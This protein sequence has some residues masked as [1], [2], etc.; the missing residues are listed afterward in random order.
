MLRGV[1][2]VLQL[3]YDRVLQGPLK[4]MLDLGNWDE[5]NPDRDPVAG[6]EHFCAV[7]RIWTTAQHQGVDDT[8]A[9]I[10]D[11]AVDLLR[12]MLGL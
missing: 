11:Q 1:G 12:Q 2:A 7:S 8:D 3:G 10:Y 6:D 5:I 4:T 9:A